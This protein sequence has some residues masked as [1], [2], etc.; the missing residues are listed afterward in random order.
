MPGG[1]KKLTA[2]DNPKPWKK[3][4]SGNPKGRPPDLI[5]TM[6]KAVG[7]EK[8]LHDIADAIMK[9]ALKGDVKAAEFVYDRLYGKPKQSQDIKIEAER[10]IFT[11]IDLNIKE[12]V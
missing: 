4:Q 10:P 8:G 2:K 12:D 3:G 5:K 11:S 9:K 6:L 1:H 7:D